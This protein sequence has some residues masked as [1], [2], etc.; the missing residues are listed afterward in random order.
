MVNA[1][2]ILQTG[3]RTEY[4]STLKRNSFSPIGGIQYPLPKSPD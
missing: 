4:V 2:H 1:F 3:Q